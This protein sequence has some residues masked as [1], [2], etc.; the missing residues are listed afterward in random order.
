MPEFKGNA[1][2]RETF[3]ID[4]FILDASWVESEGMVGGKATLQVRTA[5]V[6]HGSPIKATL[7]NREGK[8]VGTVEGV[9]YADLFR[10]QLVLP[11]D[12]AGGAYFEA[13][14]P[15]HG[16]KAIGTRLIVRPQGK[17]TS[18]AWKDLATGGAVEKIKRGTDLSVEVKTEGIPEGAEA[19]VTFRERLSDTFV[20]D[21]ATV[22]ATV[23]DKK[24]ALDWRFEYPRPTDEHSS[25]EEL[26]RTGEEYRHPKV[27]FEAW[28]SGLTV[29]GPE[30]EFIDGVAIQVVDGRGKPAAKRKV[31]VTLPDGTKQEAETDEQGQVLIEES[32]PGRVQVELVPLPEEKKKSEGKKAAPNH[33]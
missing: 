13:E 7:K 5:Y 19:S 22:P 11:P 16:L 33:A 27:F 25:S 17:L 15:K 10:K 20:R 32:A 3:K 26:K 14:L 18:P 23:K 4:S 31:K 1:D 6:S 2:K 9:V 24:I 28:C 12:S 30:A 21:L 8:A 29:N